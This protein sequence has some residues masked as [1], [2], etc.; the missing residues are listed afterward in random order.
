M[1]MINETEPAYTWAMCTFD[2]AYRAIYRECGGCVD[3]DAI[4]Y[5]T[6]FKQF[7]DNARACDR[8]V[9]QERKCID[10]VCGVIERLHARADYATRQRSEQ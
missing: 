7:G 3:A 9:P 4:T 1:D 5:E 10:R 8:T 6:A 2:C